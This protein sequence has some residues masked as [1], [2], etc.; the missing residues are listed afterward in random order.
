[1]S[2]CRG[3]GKKVVWGIDEKGHKIPLD[4]VP[5]VYDAAIGTNG[6]AL[7]YRLKDAMVSHFATC[8]RA[9]DFTKKRCPLCN[10][11]M[12]YRGDHLCTHLKEKMKT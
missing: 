2:H 8:R 9:N 12:T 10:K 11:E 3:C 7:V 1:M 5:P 4:P 6:T